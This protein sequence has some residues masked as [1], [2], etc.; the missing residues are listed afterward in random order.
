MTIRP[1][2]DLERLGRCGLLAAALGAS[3]ALPGG[4]SGCFARRFGF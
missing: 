4:V 3:H 1:L 2:L